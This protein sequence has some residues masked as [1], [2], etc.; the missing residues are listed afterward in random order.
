MLLLVIHRTLISVF[1][2]RAASFFPKGVR[3]IIK[4]LWPGPFL[5]N[6]VI[7]KTQKP[8][9]GW[10]DEWANEKRMYN[11]LKDLQGKVIPTFYGEARYNGQPALILSYVE[12]QVLFEASHLEVAEVRLKLEETLLLLQGHGVYQDDPTLANLILVDG[13]R[14]VTVD[15]ERVY[16]P[17][18]TDDLDYITECTIDH[19]LR[20]YE[21]RETCYASSRLLPGRNVD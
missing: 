7:L 21:G 3:G 10:E 13:E 9:P 16:E 5:P 17:E 18:H 14:L 12:G 15:L 1:I 2:A 19:I 8:E 20:Y 4:I 11:K 6:R